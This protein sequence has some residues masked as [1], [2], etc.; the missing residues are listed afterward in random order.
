MSEI[1]TQYGGDLRDVARFAQPVE[2]GGERLLQGQ[3][4]CLCPAPLPA[5]Q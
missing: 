3:R 5:L 2:P 4:D 1:T